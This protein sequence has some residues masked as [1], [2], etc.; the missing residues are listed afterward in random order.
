MAFERKDIWS[1]EDQ[2]EW[3]PVTEAYARA[4]GVMKQRPTSVVTSWGFQAAIHASSDG[5]WR[6]QCQH[7]CWFFLPWHRAYLYWFEQIVRAAMKEVDEIEPEVREAWA[8]PYWN[9][10]RGGRFAALPRAF[11]TE[12]LSDGTENPL[13]ERERRQ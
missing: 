5:D 3:H 12:T 9:Y 1:L 13:F 6:Q 11:W 4:V 8:L 7:N 2:Q 10:S